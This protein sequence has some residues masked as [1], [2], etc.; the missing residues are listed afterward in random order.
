MS[1]IIVWKSFRSFFRQNIHETIWVNFFQIAAFFI[2]TVLLPY[3]LGSRCF[4]IFRNIGTGWTPA[5]GKSSARTRTCTGTD[6]STKTLVLTEF[7]TF[8]V[9]RAEFWCLLLY[10]KLYFWFSF[11]NEFQSFLFIFAFRVDPNQTKLYFFSRGWLKSLSIAQ[12]FQVERTIFDG[13]LPLWVFRGHS[14][15]SKFYVHRRTCLF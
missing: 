10:K 1:I 11:P 9:E 14:E 8:T 15:S 13:S 4:W 2:E 12:H 5:P 3:L 7:S 6:T